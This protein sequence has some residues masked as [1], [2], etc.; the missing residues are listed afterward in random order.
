MPD[1]SP[2]AGHR[3]VR[4]YLLGLLKEEVGGWAPSWARIAYGGRLEDILLQQANK[5]KTKLLTR[6]SAGES[7]KR[8]GHK[9]ASAVVT[10]SNGAS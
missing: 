3:F 10:W 7:G 5:F 2:A 1:G 4:E 9:I 8:T 6:G